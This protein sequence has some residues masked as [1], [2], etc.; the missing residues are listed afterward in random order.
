VPSFGTSL[1]AG[2]LC[3]LLSDFWF[4]GSIVVLM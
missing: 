3:R 4:R 2:A 1:L